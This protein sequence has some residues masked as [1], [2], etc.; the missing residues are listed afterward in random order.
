MKSPHEFWQLKLEDRYADGKLVKYTI[1]FYK[2][3]EDGWYDELRYDS[4]EKKN[5]REVVAPHFHIKLRC[6]FKESVERG[7]SEMHRFIDEHL[8]TLKEVMK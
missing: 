3:H 4:H 2:K 7:V 8:E 6:D 5:G 1:A